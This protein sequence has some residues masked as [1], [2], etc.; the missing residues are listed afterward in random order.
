M[1]TLIQWTNNNDF[2]ITIC[3]ISQIY[4]H[5]I[6]LCTVNVT[7]F[8]SC[9]HVTLDTLHAGSVRSFP[10]SCLRRSPLFVPL[11]VHL[12]LGYLHISST[13]PFRILFLFVSSPLS[14]ECARFYPYLSRLS[15]TPNVFLV[16]SW[17][18]STVILPFRPS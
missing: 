12:I 13:E 18:D 6:Y 9:Y 3:C 7:R 15:H 14:S 11:S 16:K 4:V 17:S 10:S 5:P 1:N 8:K 2:Y